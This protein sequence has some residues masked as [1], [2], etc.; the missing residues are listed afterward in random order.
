MNSGRMRIEGYGV[1]VSSLLRR[2]VEGRCS[3]LF[4]KNRNLA[5]LTIEIFSKSA[6]PN[7]PDLRVRGIA[8]LKD[9]EIEVF[10][11]GITAYLGLASMLDK[12]DEALREARWEDDFRA[13]RLA[14]AMRAVLPAKA[15]S[16]P[17]LAGVR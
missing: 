4:S 11:S 12:L 15:F 9:K 10:G 1:R 17:A 3:P 14:I 13:S 7:R 8:S 5:Q 16:R 2:F 6:L